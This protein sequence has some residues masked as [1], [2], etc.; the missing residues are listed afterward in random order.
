MLGDN[1][2]LNNKG[3]HMLLF[4]AQKMGVV[5]GVQTSTMSVHYRDPRSYENNGYYHSEES[6]DSFVPGESGDNIKFFRIIPTSN[7]SE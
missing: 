1:Y 4:Y 3:L 6:I 5:R 2:E 7:N